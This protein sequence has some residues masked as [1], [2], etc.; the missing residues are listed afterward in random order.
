MKFLNKDRKQEDIICLIC[1]VV[2]IVQC[3]LIAVCNLTLG[4]R[5]IDCDSAKLYTHAIE[6]VRNRSYIIPEWN[7]I[8][9]LELDCSLL[10]AVP[11]FA[12]SKNI[13]ISFGIANLIMIAILIGTLF[14]LFKNKNKLHPLLCAIFIL[15]PYRIGQLDYFNMMFFNGSQYI[16]K[17]LIP[18][19]LIAILIQTK[20]K[21]KD[22]VAN[23]LFGII[24]SVFLFISCMSSGVYVPAVGIFPVFAGFILYHMLNREMLSFNFWK[25][26][27]GSGILVL[28]GL[29]ANSKFAL[30]A[31]GNS[32][33]LCS[34]KEL[35]Q[36]IAACFWGM[37]EL[38]GG[39]AYENIPVMSFEGIKVLLH[40]AFVILLLFAGIVAVNKVIRKEASLETTLLITV[41]LWNFFIL[42]V[43]KTKYG[44]G[45]FEYRY[46]LIGMIPLICIGVITVIE[47]FE[48]ETKYWKYGIFS[49]LMMMIITL[50]M[51]SYKQVFEQDL[52]S[53]WQQQVC[54]WCKERGYDRVYFYN[55]STDSE[56]L[57]LMDYKNDNTIYLTVN[58]EGKV[59]SFDYYSKYF[60]TPMEEQ[61]SVIFV[62]NGEDEYFELAGKKYKRIDTIDFWG[63]YSSLDNR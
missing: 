61:N 1:V 53:P 41:F 9:T 22:R 57:R 7:I 63:I 27:I 14:Y 59:L 30:G 58:D 13:Y 33:T 34:V 28:S 48:K 46:H 37:F 8:T 11:I 52:S 56:I 49:I 5:N 29:V 51:T 26:G 4:E 42:C 20:E 47:W 18:L 40:M 6:M 39:V 3:I 44:A 21:G 62:A 32:M 24:Y 55:N 19:L 35:Y 31:K 23:V 17:V 54:D 45:T 43:C 10:F 12:L 60:C 25:W 50:H 2:L 16:I 15:I 36:N 38:F